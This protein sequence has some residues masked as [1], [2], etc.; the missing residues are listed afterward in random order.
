[1]EDK[2]T[3]GNTLEDRPRMNNKYK[4]VDTCPCWKYSSQIVKEKANREAYLQ[5]ADKVDA[6]TQ[7]EANSH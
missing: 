7:V 4:K 5:L 3:P 2:R 1:M 6:K